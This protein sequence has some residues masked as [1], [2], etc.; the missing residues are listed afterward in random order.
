MPDM[1]EPAPAAPPVHPLVAESMRK[2]ALAWLT[3]P[4]ERA[5]A[6]WVLWHGDAL[7]V[8]HGGGEQPLPGLDTV[9]SC[10][11]TVRSGDNG[12]RIVGWQAWVSRVQ[13]GGEEWG[14]VVPLLLGK[15]LNLP[16]PNGAEERWATGSTVSRLTPASRPD[17]TLPDG[18][19]AESPALTPA[20][21][22]AKVPYTLHRTPRS[23]Q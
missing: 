12:A 8:V 6:A 16:E 20:T 7:Y 21:T 23:K 11:V 17:A 18:S 14:T 2:A 22:P 15:R 5:I 10:Q 9:T 4:G 1:T 19:L 3:V 13:P